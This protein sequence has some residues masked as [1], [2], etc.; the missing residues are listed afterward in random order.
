MDCICICSYCRYRLVVA[1]IVLVDIVFSFMVSLSGTGNCVAG[2]FNWCVEK[3][4]GAM[5]VN[6]FFGVCSTSC[7]RCIAA[8]A[9]PPRM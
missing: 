6:I 3:A 1:I 4:E 5:G 9:N 2:E 8:I 7:S